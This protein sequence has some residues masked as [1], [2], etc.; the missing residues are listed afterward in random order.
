MPGDVLASTVI[1]KISVPGEGGRVTSAVL[2]IAVRPRGVL[3]VMFTLPDWPGRVETSMVDQPEY[4]WTIGIEVGKALSRN[5]TESAF[6]L[7][8]A[9]TACDWAGW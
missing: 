9:V 6:T 4:P 3:V 2:R 1:V 7:L 8:E 5:I